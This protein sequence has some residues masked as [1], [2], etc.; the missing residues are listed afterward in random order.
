M[1]VSLPASGCLSGYL[2]LVLSSSMYV[3]LSPKTP[4]LVV[5]LVAIPLPT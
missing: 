5:K 1:C 2:F 4:A 3:S